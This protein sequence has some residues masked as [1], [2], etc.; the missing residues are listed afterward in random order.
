MIRR[1]DL[2]TFWKPA[3]PIGEPVLLRLRRLRPFQF[4]R[5]GPRPRFP[6][7]IRRLCGR[8]RLQRLV[9]PE[10]G[11]RKVLERDLDLRRLPGLEAERRA[12]ELDLLRVLVT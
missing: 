2:E 3:P 5:R 11:D 6:R 8:L 10:Q 1:I 12:A 7:A 4:D 9:H